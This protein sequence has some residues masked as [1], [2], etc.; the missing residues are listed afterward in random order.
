[1][2]KTIEVLVT[3]K[4]KTR[5]IDRLKTFQAPGY[6]FVYDEPQT[7][8]FGCDV[9]VE[10]HDSELTDQVAHI[11]C[12]SN[13]K[14]GVST[15]PE[16]P[17]MISLEEDFDK[18]C[19]KIFNKIHMF[20]VYYYNRIVEVAVV[21][22]VCTGKTTLINVLEKFQVPGYEF[23]YH[24]SQVLDS[25]HD[26]VIGTFS[27]EL[28]YEHLVTEIEESKRPVHI[29]FQNLYNDGYLL[30]PE[31]PNIICLK[32]DDRDIDNFNKIF[33]KIFEKIFMLASCR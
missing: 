11:W 16:N 12:I 22:K 2:V 14:N 25:T 21:G 20:A 33:E 19:E 7:P 8:I 3:G 5:L 31:N 23:I 1:M 28:S 24:E 30:H 18:M 13:F 9:V 26:V 4:N 10:T 27:S 29:W 17:S 6:E 15:P 32:S